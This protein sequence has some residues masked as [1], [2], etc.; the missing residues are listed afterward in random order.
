MQKQ[1]VNAGGRAVE[2]GLSF[3][4]SLLADYHPR[5]F[6]TARSGMLNRDS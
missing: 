6:G 2:A 1:A 5:D 4:K 3:L